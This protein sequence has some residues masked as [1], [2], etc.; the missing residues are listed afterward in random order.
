MI[1]KIR[2]FAPPHPPQS[3]GERGGDHFKTSLEADALGE[4]KV[5][6][7]LNYL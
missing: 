5:R 6:N 3:K 2:Y 7:S 1:S 4:G